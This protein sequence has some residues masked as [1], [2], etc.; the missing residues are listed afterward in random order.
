MDQRSSTGQVEHDRH[1]REVTMCSAVPYGQHG[2]KW[3]MTDIPVR[4][5]C[6]LQVRMANMAV[7]IWWSSTNTLCRCSTLLVRKTCIDEPPSGI[8]GLL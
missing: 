2:D 1:Y 8:A 3:S 5:Q 7:L 6:A 4:S